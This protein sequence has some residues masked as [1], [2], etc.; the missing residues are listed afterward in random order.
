MTVP[1]N[2]PLQN[3]DLKFFFV[4]FLPNEKIF[5]YEL[6]GISMIE[7]ILQSGESSLSLL[8]LKR[9][10]LSV[11]KQFYFKDTHLDPKSKKMVKFPLTTHMD[12]EGMVDL[13]PHEL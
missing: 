8:H 3:F 10:I 6:K 7:E 13:S 11:V 2:I 4:P 12:E 5:H 9:R 1:I